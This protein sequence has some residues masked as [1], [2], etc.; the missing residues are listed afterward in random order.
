[1]V[2]LGG[3]AGLRSGEILALN[4]SDVDLPARTLSVERSDRRG[5][6]TAPK[7]GR[8]RPATEDAI[9]LLDGPS[10]V[11]SSALGLER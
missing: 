4:W 6:V 8:V 3:D 10:V 2:L 1:M 11:P 7:S 9:R 5:H